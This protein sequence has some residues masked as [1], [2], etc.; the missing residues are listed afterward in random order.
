MRIVEINSVNKGSTGNIML[1][2]TDIARAQ[3]HDVLVCYPRCRDNM[4][5]YQKGD[6]LIG[7][8]VSRNIGRYLSQHYKAERYI[9][10]C[11]TFALIVRLR[12]F[13]PD[14]IHIHNIHDSFLNIPLFFSYIKRLG[15]P[16]V[17]TLH[18]CWLYTGH[19]PYYVEM[20]CSKWQNECVDCKYY[21]Q[22]PRSTYDDSA[23]KFN[24]KKRIL[25]GLE[26]KLTLAPVSSWLAGE[27]AKSFLKNVR[28]RVM[29]NGIDIDVFKPTVDIDVRCKYGISNGKIIL[30]AATDWGERK[31]LNDYYKLSKKLADDEQIV[32]VG[33][34][35]SIINSLPKGIVGIRRTDSKEDMAKLYSL[36]DV[37]LSLSYAETFGL[38]IVEANACGTPVV[39]YDNTA[40]PELVHSGNGLIVKTGDVEAVYEAIGKILKKDKKTWTVAC[41]S[42]AV[43]Y[44]EKEMYMKYIKLFESLI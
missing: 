30:A 31:G 13:R 34:N 26:D 25:L 9:H 37:V 22:Y 5:N 1:G 20:A 8:R 40:Q 2:V 14:V 15:I 19:C 42:V 44:A 36:A 41:E 21:N 28:C 3:G 43:A 24:L 29:P 18:D 23:Y 32:L 6:Y 11:S 4:K 27:V 38:T 39:V 7:N 16:V 10:I 17:W 12:K 35:D 33:V